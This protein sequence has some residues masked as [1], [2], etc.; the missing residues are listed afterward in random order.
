MVNWPDARY[1]YTRTI[2]TKHATS[3]HIGA[4]VMS[5]AYPRSPSRH[6]PVSAVDCR[7]EAFNERY[8]EKVR[9][10]QGFGCAAEVFADLEGFC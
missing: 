10:E 5:E 6:L 1:S 9:L 8:R 4:T 2:E 7:F 3:Q